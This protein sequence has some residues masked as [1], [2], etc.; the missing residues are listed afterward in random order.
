MG[1]RDQKAAA[2]RVVHQTF[3]VK[4]VYIPADAFPLNSNSASNSGTEAFPEFE[5]RVHEKQTTLGDQAGTSLN[6]AERFEAIPALIFWRADLKAKGIKLKRGSVLS[7][8][9]GEAYKL[10]VVE[11]HDQETVKVRITRMTGAEAAGLPLPVA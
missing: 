2:R 4:C 6:T 9:E 10:D 5:V 8:S 11:P 7:V 1:W 3:K